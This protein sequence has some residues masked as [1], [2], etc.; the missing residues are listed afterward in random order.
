M[1]VSTALL[2][3]DLEEVTFV[4]IREGVTGVEGMVWRI[5]KCLYGLKQSPR[6]WNQTIDKVLEEIGFFRSK[7]DHGVYGSGPPC[8]QGM[9]RIAGMIDRS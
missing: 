7:T 1:D 8:P 5:L 9:R 3:A 2:Y 6:M 4:E